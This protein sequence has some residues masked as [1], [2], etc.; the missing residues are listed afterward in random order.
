MT[1]SQSDMQN[2]G[3]SGNVRP[4]DTVLKADSALAETD[5]QHPRCK[6]NSV[7]RFW[8]FLFFKC[9][10]YASSLI[11]FALFAGMLR[12]LASDG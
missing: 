4:F 12:M 6:I 1:G 8:L 2:R 7:R 9:C 5:M 11:L 3:T 10:F